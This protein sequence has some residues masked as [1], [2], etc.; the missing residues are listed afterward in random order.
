MSI[1]THSPIE[2]KFKR[3]KEGS[4]KRE[5]NRHQ[6]VGMSHKGYNGRLIEDPDIFL[7]NI[8]IFHSLARGEAADGIKVR[9]P[10]RKACLQNS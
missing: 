5:I 2:K 1:E 4:Q 9:S 8:P 6:S 3:N 7:S 10:G